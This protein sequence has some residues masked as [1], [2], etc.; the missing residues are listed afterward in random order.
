MKINR[1]D[2][3]CFII[4]IV[5]AYQAWD[6]NKFMK[7]QASNLVPAQDIR[8]Q[9]GDW[10]PANA[11][12]DWILSGDLGKIAYRAKDCRFIDPFGLISKDVFSRSVREVN[13]KKK[14]KYIADTFNIDES[15]KMVY[16]RV[17]N[18]AF[19]PIIGGKYT[20]DILLFI[21]KIDYRK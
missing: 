12:E 14:P 19:T 5:L 16:K 20:D 4:L 1:E 8:G 15:G 10:L 13:A 6:W 21:A 9:I 3:I 17:K 2:L 7:Y 11:G 18:I